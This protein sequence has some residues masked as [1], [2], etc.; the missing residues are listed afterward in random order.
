MTFGIDPKAIKELIEEVRAATKLPLIA[1]LSPNVTDITVIAKAAVSAGADALSLI[2]TVLG[3]AIDIKTKKPKLATVT[4]GLSG[5]AIKPIAIRMVW[6][7]A[8]VVK[9]PLI[10]IGGIMTAEDAYEFL[11]AGA[12]AVQIGTANFVDVYTPLKIIEGLKALAAG[13][14]K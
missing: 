6:Q 12:S 13:K 8:Q 11:L 7:V 5:P 1:K 4:G 10:G 14:Q 2:N 9:V 3:M